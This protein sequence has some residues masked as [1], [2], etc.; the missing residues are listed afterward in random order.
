MDLR[1]IFIVWV[2][3]GFSLYLLSKIPALGVEIDTP[4]EA[5]TSAAVLGIVTAVVKPI[6][7]VVFAA[8]DFVTID[9]LSSFSTFVITVVCFGLTA[10]LV[11]GFRL[12]LGIWSAVI[13][14]FTLSVISSL[15]YGLLGLERQ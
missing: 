14:A 2:L 5:F 4:G 11:Q 1:S 10:S 8:I 9:L 13:G 12:R 6:F 15:V 7:R 3:T